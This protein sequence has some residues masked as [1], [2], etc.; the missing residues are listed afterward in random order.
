MADKE[1]DPTHTA[2]E[3]V[4]L[5]RKLMSLYLTSECIGA[6]KPYIH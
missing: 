5:S 2:T 3:I 4:R 1:P 6:K